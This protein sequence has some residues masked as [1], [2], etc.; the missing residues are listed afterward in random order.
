MEQ[1]KG[2]HSKKGFYI[3]DYIKVFTLTEIIKK[4]L[5]SRKFQPNEQDNFSNFLKITKRILR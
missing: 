3:L 1:L 2:I 4:N 5:C